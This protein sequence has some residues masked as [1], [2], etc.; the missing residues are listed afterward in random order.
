[1]ATEWTLS[2]PAI[3]VAAKQRMVVHLSLAGSFIIMGVAAT[4]SFVEM[5]PTIKE[6]A[7][8]GQIPWALATLIFSLPFIV[9]WLL[10]WATTAEC[11]RVRRLLRVGIVVPAMTLPREG[12]GAGGRYRYE[13][14]GSAH[15][16]Y[17]AHAPEVGKKES[18]PVAIVDPERPHRAIILRVPK[19]A[20][21]PS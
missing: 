9:P 20:P 12:W 1:M 5:L 2:S 10:A 14:E 7:W 11:T 13:H 18:V 6:S 4:F 15:T 21:L 3:K 16:V 8:F 19:E 17:D